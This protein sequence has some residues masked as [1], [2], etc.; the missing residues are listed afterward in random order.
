LDADSEQNQADSLAAA[1]SNASVDCKSDPQLEC[2]AFTTHQRNAEEQA[3]LAANLMNVAVLSALTTAVA[4]VWTVSS[5]REA[6]TIALRPLIHP[7]GSA[8][9]V[10]GNF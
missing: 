3:D 10:Q 9:H 8:L 4:Y 1:L 2:A 7:R 6:P 5:E